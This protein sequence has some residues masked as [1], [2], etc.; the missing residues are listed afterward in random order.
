MGASHATLCEFH[1]LLSCVDIDDA[2]RTTAPLSYV[3]EVP[4]SIVLHE[5]TFETN[6]QFTLWRKRTARRILATQ[7]ANGSHL[8]VAWLPAFNSGAPSFYD[9]SNSMSNP[10][11]NAADSALTARVNE[12]ISPVTLGDSATPA[13]PSGIGLCLSGG[14]YRAMVFHIGSIMRLNEAGMLPKLA[15]ISSV[16]GGSITAG[17][18]ALNWDSMTFV[19]NVASN[20]QEKFVKPLRAMASETID[21]ESIL[22]GIFL[23]GSIGDKIASAYDQHLFHKKT[24]QDI[25]ATGPRFIINATNMQSG[26]LWRFS[27]KEMRDYRV[28]SIPNPAVRLAV[29][30]AASSA[31]PPVLSPVTL[32]VDPKSFAPPDGSE[33]L[34]REPFTKK[35]MLS[36]GGVYDNLG[37]EAVYKRCETVLVSDAGGKMQAEEEPKEDWA[38]HSMRVLDVIDNQVRSLRKRQLIASFVNNSKKGTYWGIRTDIG[39]YNVAD[40]LPCPFARTLELASLK[41]RL[42]RLDDTMQERLINWGYAVCDAALRAHVVPTLSKAAGF[43]YPNVGV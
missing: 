13:A 1:S 3:S 2:R 42:K 28:G 7:G 10:H 19:N 17:V 30:V 37:L 24:L 14:G 33:D 32:R 6:Q 5:Q 23:P 8:S 27:R 26:V 29:A 41:T 4:S 40:A 34:H 9:R 22:G 35:I 43:P 11:S 12:A 38:R 18:L 15:R 20:L 36:D 25:T 39:D 31:F 21:A 16:S